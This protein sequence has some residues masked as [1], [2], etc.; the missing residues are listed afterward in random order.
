MILHLIEVAEHARESAEIYV[1]VGHD[2]RSRGDINYPPSIPRLVSR[3]SNF[4]L[5]VLTIA[6]TASDRPFML[7]T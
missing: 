5:P 1:T 6:Q 7:R 2:Q 4:T 3:M